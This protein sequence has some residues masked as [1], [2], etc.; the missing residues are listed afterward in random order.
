MEISPFS[1]NGFNFLSVTKSTIV[2]FSDTI[3][4]VSVIYVY[5]GLLEVIKVVQ[6]E[7]VLGSL[8]RWKLNRSE[9]I[10]YYIYVIT[11][12]D[13]NNDHPCSGDVKCKILGYGFK[14]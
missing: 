5:F 3:L 4:F 8:Y 6:F 12:A 11:F 1:C 7:I 10:Y 14:S 9:C 13:F 2:I